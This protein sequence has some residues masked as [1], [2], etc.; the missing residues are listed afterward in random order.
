WLVPVIILLIWIINHFLRGNED[1]RPARRAR[2]AERQGE[3]RPARRSTSEIDRFLDEVNRRR[4]QQAERRQQPAS[5][6]EPATATPTTTRGTQSAGQTRSQPGRAVVS[7]RVIR[8]PGERARERV[9]Q[10]EPV[11]LMEVL[12]TKPA[13]PA[14]RD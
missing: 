11:V 13:A 12:P 6:Q 3:G 9:L 14:A 8:S 10:A 2:T 4:R 7:S 5:P 1:D